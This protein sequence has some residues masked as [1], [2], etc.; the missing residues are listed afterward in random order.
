MPAFACPCG[1]PAPASLPAPGRTPVVCDGCG[2]PLVQPGPPAPGAVERG[3]AA[4]LLAAVGAAWGWVLASRATV[5]GAPWAIPAGA[6]VV[7]AAVWAVARTRGPRLQA[8]ALL[9]FVVFLAL[10][11]VMLYRQTLRERLV[12]MHAA[13][14]SREPELLADQELREMTAG[15]YLGIE[16]GLAWWACALGGAAISWRLLRAPAAVAAFGPP[17]PARA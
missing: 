3:L 13:E 16:V 7:G 2:T 10:G 15:R 5:S 12:A 9:A 1:L 17:P 14:R 8:A 11:E 6:L 4:G